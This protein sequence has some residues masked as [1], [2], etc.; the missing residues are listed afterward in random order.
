[1]AYDPDLHVMYIAGDGSDSVL[2]VDER[3]CRPIEKFAVGGKVSALAMPSARSMLFCALADSDRV[4][5][6][7]CGTRQPV[8]Q[9]K[10]GDRPGGM[11][12]CDAESK[13]Y[14]ANW[15]DT[16]VSVIDLHA[17]TVVATIPDV[18]VGWLPLGMCYVPG[19]RRLFCLNQ[20]KATVA[21][22]DATSDT[23]IA[24]VGFGG[25][26]F[27]ALCYNSS[28]NRV[29]CAGPGEPGLSSIDVTTC[30]AHVVLREGIDTYSIACDSI[31]NRI[32]VPAWPDLVVVD[33]RTD[34]V[35][36]RVE[37]EAGAELAYFDSKNNKVFVA[38]EDGG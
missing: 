32:Y 10:V 16:S 35:V 30:S 9:Y 34:T 38:S 36:A 21:V 6:L 17:D 3:T 7:D 28:N 5:A 22:I 8:T 25:G 20:A 4:V 19:A 11:L 15:G 14:V 2:T 24:R 31:R 18:D 26:C 37:I 1:L 23:I 33:G 27:S 29:Y 12:Y 13:L